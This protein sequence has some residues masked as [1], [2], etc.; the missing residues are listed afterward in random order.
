MYMR[1]H[2]IVF[3]LIFSLKVVAQGVTFVASAP[4]YVKIGEQFQIQ[5]SV[6]K[7]IDDFTP[8]DFTGFQMLGGPMQGSS[9][10]ISI[11]NG[12]TEKVYS[13]SLTYFL[14]GN[15]PGKYTIPPAQAEIKGTIIKSNSVDI[16]VVGSST[17][18]GNQSSGGQQEKSPAATENGGK[19]IFVSLILSKKTAYVGEQ[20]TAWVKIYTKYSISDYDQNYKGPEFQGFYKDKLK[21]PTAPENPSG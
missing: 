1:F 7:N 3:L 12:K 2:Y 6:N 8:P 9:T 11:I 10:N 21:L 20:I 16:E 18:S 14:M 19:D 15:K 13:Y 4:K 5:F 17:Q